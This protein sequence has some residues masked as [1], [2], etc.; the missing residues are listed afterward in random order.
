MLI[1]FFACPENLYHDIPVFENVKI[2]IKSIPIIILSFWTVLSRWKTV[3]QLLLNQYIDTKDKQIPIW[4][5]LIAVRILLGNIK[6]NVIVHNI[7]IVYICTVKKF[8][9]IVLLIFY[10]IGTIGATI[11]LHY[12][13][14]RFVGWSLWHSKESKCSKCGMKEKS[15]GCCKDEHKQIK[16]KSDQRNVNTKF[17]VDIIA[18]PVLEQSYSYATI[19]PFGLSAYKGEM[20]SN[21]P[22]GNHGVKRC[23][24]HC[25]YR[26]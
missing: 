12:C 14:N 3:G 9:V 21:A 13:M 22:P 18:S 6:E 1:Q 7:P 16:L 25:I 2:L 17:S 5:L 11:H 20:S 8:A 26:L 15:N 23:I 4:L 19:T 24:L 10:S